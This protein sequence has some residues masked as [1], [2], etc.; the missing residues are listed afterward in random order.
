MTDHLLDKINAA[1]KA[2]NEAEQS[3][4]T[5]RDELVS[6]SK[7]AGLLLLEAKKQHPTKTD[8]EA[9]LDRV[10]D[11]KISRA[12]DLL[13]LAGG[14]TTDE[15]LRKEARDRQAKSRANKKKTLPRPEPATP[16][17]KPLPVRDVT[18]SE[19]EDTAAKREAENAEAE[20]D[21]E[22][23]SPEEKAAKRSAKNLSEFQVACKIYLPKLTATDLK[24]ARTFVTLDQWRPKTKK[25]A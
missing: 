24:T 17:P 21:A 11:L 13:R 25:V 2:V 1:V 7:T 19:A 5:A 3:V 6:R 16:E 4:D 20:N 22:K 8:F 12:Y 14:R 15:E 18:D 23:H 9:Y 10:D